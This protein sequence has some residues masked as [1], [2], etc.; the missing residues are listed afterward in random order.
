MSF[1]LKSGTL[2]VALLAQ[3]L[4]QCVVT[5]ALPQAASA[6]VGVP[7][8]PASAQYT[9]VSGDTCIGIGNKFGI[10]HGQLQRFNRKDDTCFLGLGEILCIPADC[11]VEAVVSG[12]NCPS[13][14]AR[15]SLTVEQVQEFNNA[16]G[17]DVCSS[18]IAETN[19]CKTLPPTEFLPTTK[20]VPALVAA[21]FPTPVAAPVAALVTLPGPSI[22]A[23]P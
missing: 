19:L 3:C 21:G 18:L 4:T 7:D 6:P 17:A 12:D 5:N 11:E 23:G 2:V 16:L 14:A 15:T 8:C 1:S 10:R 22:T 13:F 20:D 9:V